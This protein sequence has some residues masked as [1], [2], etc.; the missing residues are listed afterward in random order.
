[1]SPGWGAGVPIRS[2]PGRFK[3]NTLA[4]PHPCA[5][6]ASLCQSPRRN[7][8]AEWGGERGGGRGG[9][10]AFPLPARQLDF[11]PLPLVAGCLFLPI[12]YL[13]ACLPAAYGFSALEKDS[14][15]FSPWITKTRL[16]SALLRPGDGRVRLAFLPCLFRTRLLASLQGFHSVS[17][18][19][20]HPLLQGA[21]E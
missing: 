16:G 17:L 18:S 9:Q 13:P 5:A 19:P 1:M 11:F 12:P 10:S 15:C 6:A 20:P 2:S 4:P 7:R 3:T 14:D 8:D 21:G